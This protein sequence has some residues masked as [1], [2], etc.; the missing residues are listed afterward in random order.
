VQ[1]GEKITTGGFALKALKKENGARLQTPS[2][3]IVLTK[4][5][6]LGPMPPIK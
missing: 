4:A 5:I 2:L 6:G 1:A 3:D